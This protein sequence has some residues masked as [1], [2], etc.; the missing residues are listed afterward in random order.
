[1]PKLRIFKIW[2]M[3]GPNLHVRAERAN[4]ENGSITMAIDGQV[5][6]A[7]SLSAI[8]CVERQEEQGDS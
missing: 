2:I 7:A 8:I 3:N 6:F 4:V 1:M 5:V